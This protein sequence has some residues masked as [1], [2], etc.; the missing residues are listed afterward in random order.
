VS[1]C[2]HQYVA[3]LVPAHA[4]TL[5]VLRRTRRTIPGSRIAGV[6]EP[7]EQ[8]DQ[9]LDVGEVQSIPVHSRP[10]P[11]ARANASATMEYASLAD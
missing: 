11:A 5:L 9:L 8:A 7:V 6:D 2:S 1:L 10:A 3:L 4:V